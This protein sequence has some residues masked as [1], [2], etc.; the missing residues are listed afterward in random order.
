MIQIARLR[1]FVIIAAGVLPTKTVS[2]LQYIKP[3]KV[4]RSQSRS[5]GAGADDK[6]STII[7]G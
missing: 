2:I 7:I 6:R 4:G 3:A 5:I 1:Q